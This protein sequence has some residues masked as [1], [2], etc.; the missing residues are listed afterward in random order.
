MK[1][2]IKV[3]P[4]I[5]EQMETKDLKDLKVPKDQVD[6][7]ETMGQSEKQ[8]QPENVALKVMK[9]KL[10]RKALKAT[11]ERQVSKEKKE[12]PVPQEN[13]AQLVLKVTR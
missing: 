2:V 6:H 11:R 5:K 4:V 12:N 10:D 7:P 9:E 13:G 1:K 8:A 3:Y